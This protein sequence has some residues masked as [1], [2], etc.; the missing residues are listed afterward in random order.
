MSDSL[1]WVSG[2]ER[3][4]DIVMVEPRLLFVYGTLMSTASGSMGRGPRARL[5]RASRTMG[6][7]AVRG[8][9]FDL[10][11]YPGLVLKL[12]GAVPGG[13]A[14]VFGELRELIEPGDV[15]DWL[16][17]Y[18]G[19]TCEVDAK[20]GC[21]YRRVVRDVARLDASGR[22]VVMPAWIYVYEGPLVGARL[23]PDGIWPP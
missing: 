7:A 23:L 9:L 19:I 6:R 12:R 1:P 20:D 15:F 13:E 16:D 2:C 8:F 22:Q 14:R 21:D 3:G 18:E 10:G 5:D 4:L 11:V 17:R